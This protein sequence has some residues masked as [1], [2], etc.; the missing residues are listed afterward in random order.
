MNPMIGITT[1]NNSDGD[2]FLRRQYCTAILRAGG[3]P[4]MLPPVGRPHAALGICDGIMLSGGGDIAPS[5]CGIDEY[6]PMFLFEPSPERD[7]YELELT[8]LAYERDIPILGICRGIQVLNTALGGSLY[9]DIVGH[10]Q[11]LS[12]EQPSHKIG[13]TKGTYLHRLIGAD[14][15]EV[16]SFH[17]QAVK[18]VPPELNV[19]AASDDGMIE[20]VE[21][22]NMRFCLGVQWHPEHMH[23]R[24]ADILFAALCAAADRK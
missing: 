21:A 3:I 9:F 19:C 1:G 15:L 6:D 20:A 24:E 4:I 22:P 13:I 12:R 16:N 7:E 2:Y 18:T 11:R 23:T 14:E 17:H 5:L 10:R 8:K